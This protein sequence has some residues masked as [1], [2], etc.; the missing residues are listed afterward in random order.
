[1]V[2]IEISKSSKTIFMALQAIPHTI[3]V[4]TVTQTSWVKIPVIYSLT[5]QN[6]RVQNQFH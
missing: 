3:P 4:A 1:M 6:P 2:I 5:D